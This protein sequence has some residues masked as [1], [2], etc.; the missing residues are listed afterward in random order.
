MKK[1]T[2]ALLLAAVMALGLFAACGGTTESAASVG[3]DASQEEAVESA[4]A[5]ASESAQEDAAEAE[6]EDEAE[7][8]EDSEASEEVEEP[9]EKGP[10]QAA[11]AE[12]LPLA[13]GAKLT[14]FVELPGY[15]SMF[16]VNSYD[17]LEVWQHA[18]E[19]LGVDVDFTI[20]N[21]ES[22]NTNFSLMVASGDITDLVSGGSQQYSNTEQMMEDGVAIDL[23]EYQDQMPNYW[24]VLDYYEDYKTVAIT[25]EGYMPEAITVA[26]DYRVSGGMQ[27]RQDWLDDMGAE[28]PTT[29]EELHDVLL[30]FTNNYGAD[31]ALLLTGSTQM[32]GSA[33]VGGFESVGF[34]GSDTGANMF[35]VD[36]EVRNGFLADGYKEYMAMMAQWFSEG[37]IAS[38]FAS[39]SNDPWTSNADRYISSGNSGVWTSQSDNMDSNQATGQDLNPDFLISPM[40]QITKDGEKFHFSDTGVGTNAMGKNVSVSE[41]CQ[42]V[43]LALAFLDFWYTDEGIKLAN[44]GIEGVSW[45]Y[46]DQGKPELNDT[47]LHNETFPMVS[48]ATTYYTL[49]CVA[50][51]QDYHRMDPAYSEK[52]LAAMELWTE[53]ADDLYTLP[54]QVELTYDETNRYSDLWSDIST[55][56]AT[57]VFK[58]VM[59]EYNFDSDWDSFLAQLDSMGLQECIDIYQA[60]YDRYVEAYGA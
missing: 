21:N 14:Y 55:Y 2:L 34:E 41:N 5:S 18:E 11:A 59:G 57:E 15:M 38:D 52:N 58:F 43:D 31:H 24:N 17:D 3:N 10:F 46:N 16:N 42:D 22:M 27:I 53:T 6:T 7:E 39:E 47:V 9:R 20:V 26:D 30:S 44:Y 37:I 60:A 25:Q 49:A 23:M 54:S 51:L 12:N 19:I 4:Q 28:I 40:A 36:G 32:Q 8:P 45:D 48:F 13:E 50:T 29:F 35:V 1:K 33:L 56:A